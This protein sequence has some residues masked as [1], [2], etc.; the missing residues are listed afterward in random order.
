[1]WPVLGVRKKGSEV[2]LGHPKTNYDQ[3]LK[4]LLMVFLKD[5]PF[6]QHPLLVLCTDGEETSLDHLLDA[7]QQNNIKWGFGIFLFLFF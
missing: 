6:S 3:M 4:L 2:I 5:S 1:M 7:D